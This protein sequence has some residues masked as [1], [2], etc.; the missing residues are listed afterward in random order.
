MTDWLWWHSAGAA[1]S[2]PPRFE[3]ILFEDFVMTV[4]RSASPNF[5]TIPGTI[6]NLTLRRI[7]LTPTKDEAAAGETLGWA[8]EAAAVEVS[9][10]SNL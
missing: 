7:S 5:A 3:N 8:C 4:R 1:P 2:G 9:L 10:T 6:K